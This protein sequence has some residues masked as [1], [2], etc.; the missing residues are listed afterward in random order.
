MLINNAI[1]IHHNDLKWRYNI[2]CDACKKF[3]KCQ[4]Q[5]KSS[6]TI[7]KTLYVSILMTITEILNNVLT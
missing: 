1:K 4:V 6:T 7:V 3:N 5:V 2:L